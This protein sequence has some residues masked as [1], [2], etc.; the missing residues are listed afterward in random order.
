MTASRADCKKNLQESIK[1]INYIKKIL[2]K[3]AKSFGYYE[4]SM[5]G[6][7]IK[8]K[9]ICLFVFNKCYL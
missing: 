8:Y 7:P 2:H 6:D 5:K 4:S 9:T 3:S 1:R